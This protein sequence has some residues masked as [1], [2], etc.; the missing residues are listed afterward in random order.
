MAKGEDL[1][2]LIR[3]YFRFEKQEISFLVPAILLTAFMFSFDNWGETELDVALGMKNF[4][5]ASVIV[6]FSVL[7]RLSWQKINALGK[8]YKAEFKGWWVGLIIG[9]II[10]FLSKGKITPVLMGS[11][12]ASFMVRHRLGSFRYGFSYF[13]NA[14]ISFWGVIANLILSL[15]FAIALY[16]FPENTFF[17]EALFFNWIM[18]LCA[19]L[20]LPQLDGLNIYFGSRG[21]YYLAIVIVAIAGILLL[22]QTQLG[23]ILAVLIAAISAVVLLLANP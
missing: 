15:I 3:D 19:I 13:E 7:V 2:T 20:P 6:A 17:R 4:F 22:T 16:F 1:R 12:V 9:L 10:T 5:L 23:L 8:G 11:V 18:A 14:L 21:L